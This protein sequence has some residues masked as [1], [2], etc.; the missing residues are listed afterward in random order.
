MDKIADSDWKRFRDMQPEVIDRFC[1]GV[2]K[3]AEAILADESRSAQER[4]G[5]L[6]GLMR[7]RDEVMADMFNGLSRT[8]A[9]IM[10]LHQCR[11][12]LISDAELSEFSEPTRRWIEGAIKL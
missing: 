11:R 9:I 1:R 7:D 8:H 12:S 2:L 4:Y 6:Y 10:L 3:E 5:G